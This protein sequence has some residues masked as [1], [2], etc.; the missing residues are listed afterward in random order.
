[1]YP[2]PQGQKPPVLTEIHPHAV[3]INW[4]VP[5][6]SNGIIKHY[7]IQRRDLGDIVPENITVVNA[8]EPLFYGDESVMPVSS[9]EYRVVAYTTAGGTP[10]PYSNIT[11]GEAGT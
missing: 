11:T 3:M 4:T 1:M 2:V 5:A 10:G 8:S 6:V 7:E 9:D